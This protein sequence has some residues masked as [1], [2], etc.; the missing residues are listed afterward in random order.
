[1]KKFIS[2][3]LALLIMAT[4]SICAFAKPKGDVDGNG[5]T[6]STDALLTLQ[7]AVGLKAPSANKVMADVDDN[8][9]VNSIDALSILQIVVGT[10]TGNKEVYET[11]YKETVV[12][13]AIRA[14][15]FTVT[16]TAAQDD[17]SYPVTIMFNNNNMAAELTVDGLKARM[18]ILDGK[19]Y[20]VIPAFF[21]Y[22]EIGAEDIGFDFD[23]SD[24]VS[25]GGKYVKSVKVNMNGKTYDKE[26]FLGDDNESVA[27]YYFLNGQLA[28]IQSASGETQ[29]IDSFKAGVDSSWFSLKGLIKI[30]VDDLNF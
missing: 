28:L 5:T 1:M 30:D 7:L 2:L 15:K 13:P 29:K 25:A 12:D 23:F 22:A 6:N 4:M 17:M 16:M 26:I 8:G 20:V 18:L 11:H 27:S 21:C 14:K 10:Y 24:I 3:S 9:T 19:T